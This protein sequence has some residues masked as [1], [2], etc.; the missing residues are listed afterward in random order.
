[1]DLGT[2]CAHTLRIRVMYEDLGSGAIALLG[3]RATLG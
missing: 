2:Y 3:T 1:M